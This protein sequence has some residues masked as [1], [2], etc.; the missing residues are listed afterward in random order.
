MVYGSVLRPGIL[1]V[2]ATSKGGLVSSG[3]QLS[4]WYRCWVRWRTTFLGNRRFRAAP[5]LPLPSVPR[6]STWAYRCCSCYLSRNR[7][8]PGLEDGTYVYLFL[9]LSCAE[10]YRDRS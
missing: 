10:K 1:Y 8:C 6:W 3:W 7:N 5:G 9:T 4:T 2:A